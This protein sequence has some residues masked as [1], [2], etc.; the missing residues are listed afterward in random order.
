MSVAW[1][2]FWDTKVFLSCRYPWY[3][4]EFFGDHRSK[5]KF[6]KVFLMWLVSPIANQDILNQNW[7]MCFELW[8]NTDFYNTDFYKIKNEKDK[9]VCVE[10]DYILPNFKLQFSHNIFPRMSVCQ[11]SDGIKATDPHNIRMSLV[12]FFCF[13]FCFCFVFVFCFVLF[14]FV[15]FVSLY[16]FTDRSKPQKTSLYN[17]SWFYYFGIF[18]HGK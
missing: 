7:K 1:C 5:T 9:P 2:I 16:I 6:V 15:F 10:K 4:V 18:A 14:C 13:C 17:N 8:A 11:S 12:F 3:R